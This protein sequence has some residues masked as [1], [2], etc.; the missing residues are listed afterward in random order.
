[1][2]QKEKL[3]NI[4]KECVFCGLTFHINTSY[5]RSSCRNSFALSNEILAAVPLI[6]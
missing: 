5:A 2:L 6:K 4:G 3:A 1:M